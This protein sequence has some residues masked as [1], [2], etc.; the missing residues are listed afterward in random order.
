MRMI[1][2]ARAGNLIGSLSSAPVFWSRSLMRT[3]TSVESEDSRLA[4]MDQP[5]GPATMPSKRMAP[6]GCSLLA[7][8]MAASLTA[9]LTRYIAGYIS[10]ASVL[11]RD[12]PL[13]FLTL[14][15]N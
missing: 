6:G 2:S 10:I 9:A 1:D 13:V 5:S 11:S 3:M 8:L 7:A 15:D 14:I 4:Q 12:A